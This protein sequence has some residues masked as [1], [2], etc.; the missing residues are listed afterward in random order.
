MKRKKDESPKDYKLRRTRET[1]DLKGRSQPQWFWSSFVRGTYMRPETIERKRREA[2]EQKEKRY[3][4]R[5]PR[6]K[7]GVK[8]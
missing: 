4:N 6:A 8:A 1:A 3:E 5:N 7:T 2:L